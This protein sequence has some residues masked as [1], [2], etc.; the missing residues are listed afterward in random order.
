MLAPWVVDEMETANLRDRRLNRRW[1]L[2]VDQL[3]RRPVASIPAACD[4]YAEMTATYRFLD[5][6]KVSFEEVLDPPLLHASTPEGTG[7]GTLEAMAW[8]RDE[9]TPSCSKLSSAQRVRVGRAADRVKAGSNVLAR[10]VRAKLDAPSSSAGSCSTRYN[11]LLHDLGTVITQVLGCC[12]LSGCMVFTDSLA[13]GAPR[14]PGLRN[15][16]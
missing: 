11:L 9:E 12:T 6:E 14:D 8:V 2:I 10:P 7:L 1:N 4:G 13:P 16:W 15:E 5:N 3:G